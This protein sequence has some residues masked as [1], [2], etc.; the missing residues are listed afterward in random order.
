LDTPLKKSP[1][2]VVGKICGACGRGLLIGA[3]LLPVNV[4]V[5][6]RIMLDSD[7]AGDAG[8]GLCIMEPMALVAKVGVM[9][10]GVGLGT[11]EALSDMVLHQTSDG[12]AEAC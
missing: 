9:A 1:C 11:R 3:G 7:N 8:C 5:V 10:E 2:D 12:V 4:L 6:D